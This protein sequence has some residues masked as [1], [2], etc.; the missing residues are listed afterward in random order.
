METPATEVGTDVLIGGGGVA[1][2]M[3]AIEERGQ[4]A[5]ALIADNARFLERAGS[6]GRGVDQLLTPLNSGPEWDTPA[7]LL[8]YVPQLTD[9]LVDI[10]VTERVV[11]EMLEALRRLEEIG[12]N[13]RDPGTGEYF[14]TRAFGLPGEYHLNFDRKTFQYQLG[15]HT[16]SCG[17][18]FLP[19]NMAPWTRSRL[20][21]RW[22]VSP[23]RWSWWPAC[24][25]GLRRPDTRHRDR[26]RGSP[27][28]RSGP[29][30][31]DGGLEGA[32]RPGRHAQDK[33]LLDR[34]PARLLPAWTTSLGRCC[35]TGTWSPVPLACDLMSPSAEPCRC[36]V[37]IEESVMP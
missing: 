35:Q 28:D 23:S 6:V 27:Q 16:V 11:N 26:L 37:R 18:T 13:F 3:A 36:C 34:V 5:R 20:G 22:P 4:S 30:Q 25:A 8:T 32:F 1:G 12:I 10:Q 7:F 19:R 15:R 29:G 21:R 24:R 33:R 17:V 2:C 31:G 14:R 9:G